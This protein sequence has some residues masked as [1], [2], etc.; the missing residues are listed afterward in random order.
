MKLGGCALVQLNTTRE[1]EYTAVEA[2]GR[3]VDGRAH[4]SAVQKH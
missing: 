2:E 3:E 4:G 1:A